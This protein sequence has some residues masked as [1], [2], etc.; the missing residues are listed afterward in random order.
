MEWQKQW[1]KLES[2]LRPNV[3]VKGLTEPKTQA[4]QEMMTLHTEVRC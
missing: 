2:H 3:K 4:G 1:Q